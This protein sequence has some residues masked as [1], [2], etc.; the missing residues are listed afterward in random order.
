MNLYNDDCLK[1]LPNIPDKSINFILCDLPYGT[2]TCSW[3]TIIPFELL[4]EQYKRIITDNGAIALFG[5]E[6]FSSYLRI[7]NIEMFKYD[8]I[9]EKTRPSNFTSAKLR[10]LKNIEIISVF[11]KSNMANGSKNNM[12][13]NPQG[14][15][16][17]DK[18]WK[19][20]KLSKNSETAHTGKNWKTERI[21]EYTNYPRQILKFSNPNKGQVHP[22]QKPVDLCQYMVK[23]Y[24][25]EGDIVLDNCMGSGTT[26]IACLKTN[27]KFIGIEK[28][29]KYFDIAK[30]RL[31]KEENDIRLINLIS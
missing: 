24:T 21:L 7:S 20:P 27:R 2:T 11:S 23:T 1:I 3:D 8:W 16:R 25:N 19:R 14:L 5:V 6:P 29:I 28:E 12:I 9:W 30:N 22:T 4:W 15:I 18:E 17:I 26:G 13:Y 31:E 10:P